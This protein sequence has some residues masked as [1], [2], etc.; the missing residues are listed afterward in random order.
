MSERKMTII[1]VELTFLG[2]E[3]E[4]V[5]R[6]DANTLEIRNVTSTQA[7]SLLD[8]LEKLDGLIQIR[9]S[10]GELSKVL[11]QKEQDLSAHAPSP[12]SEPPSA[13]LPVVQPAPLPNGPRT[14]IAPSKS[15]RNAPVEVPTIA[16]EHH[17]EAQRRGEQLHAA[18]AA[19]GL[20]VPAP[21]PAPAPA[22]VTPPAG[23]L[24][25]AEY[26]GQATPATPT[27]AGMG[28][29]GVSAT[30]LLTHV[31]NEPIVQPTPTPTPASV[32]PAVDHTDVAPRKRKSAESRG[33]A[34]VIFSVGDE[35]AGKQILRVTPVAHDGKPAIRL[36]FGLGE[37]VILGGT[38]NVLA[39]IGAESAP[40]A[41]PIPQVVA[42]ASAPVLD[43][44]TVPEVVQ[45][46]VVSAKQGQ[47]ELSEEVSI[48][49][50]PEELRAS[51]RGLDVVRWIVDN[52]LATSEQG[53]VDLVFA[54]QKS[55]VAFSTSP[56]IELVA[57]RVSTAVTLANIVFPE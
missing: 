32:E 25:L 39:E 51:K 18:A 22:Q 34:Q 15:Y 7:G 49:G 57:R 13:P 27:Q 5:W 21:A 23:V 12:M 3:H 47:S 41:A 26:V 56:T 42:T 52:K 1:G 50:L 48:P 37:G 46:N 55:L 4:V 54:A 30:K 10:L 29:P 2:N 19:A 20:D 8:T 11:A 44:F 28:V 6:R 24:T 45:P 38:G 9:G 17:A 36:D 40:P 16:P 14:D 43:I 53:V 33:P 31:V 35:F